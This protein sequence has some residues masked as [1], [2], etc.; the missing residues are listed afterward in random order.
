MFAPSWFQ[1]WSDFVGIE[2]PTLIPLPASDAPLLPFELP[3][4]A[5]N[6]AVTSARPQ[7]RSFFMRILISLLNSVRRPSRDFFLHMCS[8]KIYTRKYDS[9]Y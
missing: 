3:H 8:S 9:Y 2:T 1:R 6:A 7:A 4:P 5:K